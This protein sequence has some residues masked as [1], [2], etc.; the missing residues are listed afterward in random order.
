[1][2]DILITTS[3]FQCLSNNT[4]LLNLFPIK[5]YITELSTGETIRHFGNFNVSNK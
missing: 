2:V 3:V 1:M 4:Y 5:S